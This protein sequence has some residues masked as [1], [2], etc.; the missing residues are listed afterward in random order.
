MERGWGIQLVMANDSIHFLLD[1][2]TRPFVRPGIYKQLNFTK[3]TLSNF[4]TRDIV[5]KVG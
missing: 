2:C 1:Y 3:I 5:V 4:I